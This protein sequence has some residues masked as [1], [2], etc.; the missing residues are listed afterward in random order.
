MERGGRMLEGRNQAEEFG[1]G[2]RGCH[3]YLR[4]KVEGKGNGEAGLSGGE[5]A[6]LDQCK[7]IHVVSQAHLD[8]ALKK[9]GFSVGQGIVGKRGSPAEVWGGPFAMAIQALFGSTKERPLKETRAS[10]SQSRLERWFD[11]ELLAGGWF[12]QRREAGRRVSIADMWL[13]EE[14]ARKGDQ[15]GEG[16]FFLLE[17]GRDDKAGKEGDDE[18]S[19][20]IRERRD[21]SERVTGK[22]RK[23]QR[24]SRFDHELKKLEWGQNDRDEKIDKGWDF[25]MIRFPFERS[26]GGHLSPTMR[27]FS[28]VVEELEL[29]DL[30]LHLGGGVHVGAIQV[31]LARLVSDHSSILLDGGGMRRGPTPFRFENMWLK[32]EGFK[33]ELKQWWEGI[34]VSGSASFILT[35]KL[36]ALKPFLRS[37]NKRRRNQI[38]RIKVNERCLTE[39]SEIKEEVSRTFQGLLIDPGD[40]KPSIDGLNFERLE[41][42]D[43]ERLEK[44][45]SEEEVFE[46]LFH[47]TGRFVRSLNA[48]FLVMI[49]KKGG[50]EDLK[51]FKPI[52]LVGG[53][54]KWGRQIMDA[55]LIAN[56]AI[57]SILKSNRGAILCKLDI[58]KSYDHVDCSFFPGEW[59]PNG[60][61]PKLKGFK[62]RRPLS[63]YLFVVV[64]KAFSCLMK[65]AVA[66]GL[67]VN[68][69]KSE[70]ILVGRVEIVEELAND[71]GYKIGNLP[72]TYLR[73]PLGAPLKFVGVWD[74]IKENFERD[75]LCGSDSTSQK[76]GG[77]P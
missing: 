50:A 65:R 8:W 43:V 44:L 53:F 32:E 9:G 74:G 13:L 42:V 2:G 40:W 35:E 36:K 46:A 25:N 10:F 16:D 72:S 41:E 38:N 12:L 22:K 3:G 55:V 19:W 61:F 6:R 39:E 62:A 23:G 57:D 71:F 68:L 26:R 20:R 64:M 17:E 48:T 28:E 14:D 67:K 60:F 7:P 11:E 77:L 54:Y 69:V 75:W 33:E 52:S 51:D 73:M 5:D 21:C 24:P 58:E 29:R 37:W 4:K 66:G 56:V 31:V 47:E 76:R 63:P 30:P 34:Q 70:L 1:C 18:E 15:K 45:F 49:P 27:R 59:R